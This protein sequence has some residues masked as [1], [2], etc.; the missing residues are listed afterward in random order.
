MKKTLLH[1]Q[2]IKLNAK[3]VEFSG[4]EMPVYYTGIT[5]EHQ[6][7]RTN[8]GLFD[9]SHMGQI[10]VSGKGSEDFLQNILVSDI[11][12]LSVG[13]AQYTVMC[14][15]EGGI[16]DDLLVYRYIDRY[17]LVVNAGNLEKDL[18]WMEVN[19]NKNIS[20]EDKTSEIILLAVQGPDSGKIVS[21]IFGNEVETLPFYQFF[22]SDNNKFLFTVSR[23]G[24]TGE[25]GYEIYC[26]AENGIFLW[27]EILNKGNKYGIVPAGLG[28][29]NL[30]RM[31]MKYCLY[32]N[33]IGESTNPYEAGIGWVVSI[34]KKYFIGMDALK[35]AKNTHS[36]KLICFQMNDK[37]IPRKG[38][39]ITKNGNEIGVVTSGGF[40]SIIKAGIGLGYV[41]K[42][43]KYSEI[44][45]NIR[46]RLKTALI[47]SPPLYTHGTL[48]V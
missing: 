15:E 3:M 25:L 42:K 4:F 7:V 40:S 19:N 22:I 32:G 31:E 35:K 20:L 43:I 45:I 16:I 18:N 47:K 5:E 38:Y 41:E 23:T 27:N 12:T 9:V 17:M 26:Q 8:A 33:D 44:E 34:E 21:E 11:S 28:A 48:H 24:Y 29:R 37:A 46:G 30:L 39:K 13:C 10:I 2:H 1:N 6:T 36:R 14:N